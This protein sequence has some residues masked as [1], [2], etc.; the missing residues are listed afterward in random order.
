MKPK[1]YSLF[2]FIFIANFQ[3]NS[4]NVIIKGK[5]VNV[6]DKPLEGVSVKV[7]GH[8]FKT[9][10]D[11][12]GFYKMSIPPKSKL[13]F[14]KQYYKTKKV[15]AKKKEVIN[16]SL[17]YDLKKNKAKDVNTGFGKVKQSENSMSIATVDEKI[18]DPDKNLDIATMLRTVPGIRVIENGGELDILIRGNRSLS[19]D[20]SPL[21]ML[22]GSAYYGSLKNLNPRDIKSIDVLKGGAA[23]TAYGSRGAN[24]VILITTK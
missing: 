23:T 9:V 8:D 18:L 20:D 22:N 16:V 3:L 14:S 19:S 1:F 15:A 6:F 5:V 13:I 17:S 10:T 12:T 2:L 7:K 11:S 4:Q 21:I 24:G